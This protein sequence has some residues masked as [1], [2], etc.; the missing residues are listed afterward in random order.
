MWLSVF[1]TLQCT[2]YSVFTTLSPTVVSTEFHM[3]ALISVLLKLGE[4]SSSL[5]TLLKVLLWRQRISTVR[6]TVLWFWLLSGD[7]YVKRQA[8]HSLV[9]LACIHHGS[10]DLASLNEREGGHSRESSNHG[11]NSTKVLATVPILA[12]IKLYLKGSSSFWQEGLANE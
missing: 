12:Q 5:Q 4:R 1:K 3:E 6:Q 7:V 11:K 9:F 2:L 8:V 10:K